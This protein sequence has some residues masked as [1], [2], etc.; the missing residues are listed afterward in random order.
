DDDDDDDNHTSTNYRNRNNDLDI[1]KNKLVTNNR[2]I[3]LSKKNDHVNL[4]IKIDNDDDDNHTSTN[5][6]NRDNDRINIRNNER[7]N[8]WN[9]I[10]SVYID[11]YFKGNMN[12]TYV[13][14]LKKN[15]FNILPILKIPDEPYILL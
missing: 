4:D 3:K 1:K 5:Y 2:E 11:K 14:N 12:S 13:L 10:I 8:L 6:R 15:V 7:D 9:Q